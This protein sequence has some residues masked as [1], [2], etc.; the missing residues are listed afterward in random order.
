MMK[1]NLFDTL[2]KLVEV[3]LQLF[4]IEIKEELSSWVVQTCVMIGLILV[5]N[6][7]VIFG[8]FALA[9]LL[10]TWLESNFLGFGVVTCLYVLLF[11]GLYGGR[12]QIEA[13]I[14]NYVQQSL[15]EKQQQLE[16]KPKVIE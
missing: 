3:N 2:G 14:Y 8:S 4:K 6:M 7:V 15:F 12:K 5:V 9:F 16:N 10:G 11:L 1:E 13:T